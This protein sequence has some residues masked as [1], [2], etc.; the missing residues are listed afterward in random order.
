MID[1]VLLALTLALAL[2]TIEVK[3][4]MYAIIAFT[5]LSLTVAGLF[6]YLNAPIVALFQVIIYAGAIV[7][8]FIMAIMLTER[9]E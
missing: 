7:V 6:A 2:I 9:S 5:G 4:L 8:L 1:L 3:E